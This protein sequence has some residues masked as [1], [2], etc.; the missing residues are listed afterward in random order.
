[1]KRTIFEAEHDAF[2][3]AVRAFIAK[4][5]VPHTDAWE[6]D[7]MVD[8]GFWTAAAANGFVGFQA[9][10]EFGGA[11][12]DDFRF[13]AILDE[14][15][16]YAAAVGDNFSLENDVVAPYLIEL[17][18]D[19]QKA[20][21]LPRFTTGELVV[22]IALTEPSTGSDLRSMRATA[23]RDGD[24][25]VIN[26]SKTFITSGVQADMTIVAAKTSEGRGAD[27]LSLFAVE[28]DAPGYEV[29]R[30]LDKVGRRAQDTAELFF[31]DVRV[32]VA[33]RIGAE[34]SAFASMVRNLPTERMSMAVMA[35]AASEKALEVTLEYVKERQ[36]F[37]KAIG[38]FQA[39]RHALAQL[40]AELS[41]ARVYV[42]HCIMGVVEGTLTADEAAAA[43]LVT[44][45][46]QWRI[47]DL[48]LQMHG[49]YG[50]M[51][52]YLISRLWR[53]AR[54]QRIYG[55]TSEIMREIVGRSMGL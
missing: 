11:G 12:L 26:G 42:D 40:G 21:W 36:A 23:V 1:M 18:D 25:Y 13:N 37:G 28:A 14:E 44:T 49:G 4:E 5:A 24:E 15:M 50:Y 22:A 17:T 39:N 7:G 16:M 30:K 33:N 48:C 41:A 31:T 32:P 19:E 2:R 35:V 10:E 47:V 9:P 54:V 6:A 3:E 20:R 46:L 8:R 45:E 34:G 38:S 29:G 27:S 55:G 53:D 52:E 43:K 51:D